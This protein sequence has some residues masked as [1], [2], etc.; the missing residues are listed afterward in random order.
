[1]ANIHLQIQPLRMEQRWWFLTCTIPHRMHATE[2]NRA[3]VTI[4][5]NEA[6]AWVAHQ[7]NEVI[8]IWS[9]DG[10]A[11]IRGSAPTVIEM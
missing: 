11:N 1:M 7:T 8:A 2:G 6:A 4:D 9:S 3:T 5:G 10:R